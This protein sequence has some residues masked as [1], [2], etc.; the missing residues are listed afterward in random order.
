RSGEANPQRLVRGAQ[1]LKALAGALGLQAPRRADVD[2]GRVNRLSEERAE[3]RRQRNFKRADEIRAEIE[4][5][6]AILED[7]PGGTGWRWKARGA[8]TA[9]RGATPRLRC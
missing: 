1:E 6:G 9:C 7:K 5:L 3:A 8:T 2:E 4:Q